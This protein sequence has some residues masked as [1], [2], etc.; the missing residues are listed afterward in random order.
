MKKPF[1]ILMFAIVIILSLA[2]FAVLVNVC[3]AAGYYF[4][5]PGLP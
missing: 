3:V 1:D 5:F 2:L 4:N